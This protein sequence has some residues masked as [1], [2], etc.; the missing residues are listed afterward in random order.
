MPRFLSLAVFTWNLL[1]PNLTCVGGSDE[2]FCVP[3][4]H[5]AIFNVIECVNRV[6]QSRFW[7]CTWLWITYS[8]SVKRASRVVEHNTEQRRIHMNTNDR[9]VTSIVYVISQHVTG[10]IVNRVCDSSTYD[11]E[12]HDQND[13]ACECNVFWARVEAGNTRQTGG[14]S[15]KHT[16]T[17]QNVLPGVWTVFGRKQAVLSRSRTFL[18]LRN[19]QE[20]FSFAM[21]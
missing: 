4:Q 21:S 8:F 14:T 3:S 11:D 15:F 5:M 12:N 1:R 7:P 9:C 16:K 6:I 2:P 17:W 20:S 18:D 10:K 13:I 19:D